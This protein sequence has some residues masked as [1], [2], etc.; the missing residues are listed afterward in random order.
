METS[1]HLLKLACVLPVGFPTHLLLFPHH[2]LELKN[3][4]NNVNALPS[5]K[6]LEQG[7][8]KQS[9]RYSHSRT[10]FSVNNEKW[11]FK[12]VFLTFSAKG[13]NV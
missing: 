11:P 1:T 8:P 9:G 6:I 10:K 12:V 7:R 5:N 2:L 4:K 13:K 3:I